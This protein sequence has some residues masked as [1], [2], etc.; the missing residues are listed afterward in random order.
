MMTVRSLLGWLCA[1]VM[2]LPAWAE[3]AW[4]SARDV[5]GVTVESRDTESKYHEHRGS[6]ELCG[7]L[8]SVLMFV[9]DVDRLPQWVPW[10]DAANKLEESPSGIVYHVVTHAPWPYK[11]RDMIYALDVNL[12]GDSA[13]VSMKGVP[14][15]IAPV[16]GMVRM[17]AADGLWTF[18]TKGDRLEVN[19]RLWV[20][21]GG[22]PGLLVNRRAGTTLGRMLGNLQAEFACGK[23]GM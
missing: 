10:T 13:T 21:P 11:P 23:A 3:G 12:T 15:R 22:G 17:K 20:D 18:R 8:Q 7:D 1:L 2:V 9:S 19:L 14:D 5:G 6:V 4:Q 16:K